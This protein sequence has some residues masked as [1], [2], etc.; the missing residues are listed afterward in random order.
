MTG[1]PIEA[2]LIAA[3]RQS[4]REGDWFVAVI[5]AS[6]RWL[7][8]PLLRLRDAA[9]PTGI[10][11]RC[12]AAIVFYPSYVLAGAVWTVL[13]ALLLPLGILSLSIRALR[14]SKS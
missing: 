2:D 8:L 14:S 11:A 5:S 3:E 9:R 10:V 1:S 7:F 12:L 13:A 6:S 4:W